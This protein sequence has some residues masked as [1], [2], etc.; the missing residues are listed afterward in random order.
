MLHYAFQEQHRAE[1]IRQ[2]DAQRLVRQA[3]AVR[4]A[5]RR[6]ARRKKREPSGAV[7]SSRYTRAA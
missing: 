7:D 6:H 5:G 4:R 2:A 3:L 1:L